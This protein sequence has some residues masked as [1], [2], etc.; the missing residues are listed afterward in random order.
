MHVRA[1]WTRLLARTVSTCETNLF[2]CRDNLDCQETNPFVLFD[3]LDCQ[4]TNP[5]VYFDNLD[6]QKTNPFVFFNNLDCQELANKLEQQTQK[7]C[8]SRF[9]SFSNVIRMSRGLDG[10]GR[11]QAGPGTPG[12]GRPVS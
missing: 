4:E 11:V 8:F 9:S 7:R 10:V 6:C 1:E 2:V 3:N 12:L 5:F